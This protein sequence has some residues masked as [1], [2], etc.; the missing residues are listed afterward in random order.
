M[1][2]VRYYFDSDASATLYVRTPDRLWKQ[3]LADW[4][5]NRQAISTSASYGN[6]EGSTSL[7]TATPCPLPYGHVV[8][9]RRR[10]YYRAQCLS[11]RPIP[12]WT[13]GLA[14]AW[15]GQRVSW[16]ENEANGRPGWCS[17]K[18]LGYTTTADDKP[19]LQVRS[20]FKCKCTSVIVPIAAIC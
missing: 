12:V 9:D 20:Y 10:E 4:I 8:F 14:S 17:G 19:A 15:K 2:T 7:S 6:G 11:E 5:A 3:S 16:R 13:D 18:V 1:P